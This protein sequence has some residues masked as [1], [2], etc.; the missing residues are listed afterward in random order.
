[1]GPSP[2]LL[3][4]LGGVLITNSTFESLNRLLPE[5]L[6]TPAMR[7]RWLM[8]SAVR[9]NETGLLSP[10]EFA[11]AFVQEWGLKLSPEQFLKEFYT[12]PGGLY[13]RAQDT[14]RELRTRH[15]VACLSNCSIL[16]WEKFSAFMGEFDIALSSHLLG[17]LKPDKEAFA[18]AFKACGVKASEVCFFDDTLVNVEAARALGARAFHVDGFEAL[19]ATLRSEGFLKG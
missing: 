16:H 6:D 9:R 14:I 5:P 15:R 4:D 2:L 19:R 8:S 12:W 10:A 3:F 11:R 17:A 18:R 7:H 1:M 13:P